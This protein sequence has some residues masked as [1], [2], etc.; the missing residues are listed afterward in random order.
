MTRNVGV[1]KIQYFLRNLTRGNEN[2]QRMQ[3]RIFLGGGISTNSDFLTD[4]VSHVEGSK[5]L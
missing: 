1:K 5:N 4:S 2:L 3:Q